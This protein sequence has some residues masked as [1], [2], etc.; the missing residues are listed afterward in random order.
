MKNIFFIGLSIIGCLQET[1]VF[2]DD[3]REEK[4]ISLPDLNKR[5]LHKKSV[6]R[7]GSYSSQS[8]VKD[9]PCA[10]PSSVVKAHRSKFRRRVLFFKDFCIAVGASAFLVNLLIPE[11]ALKKIIGKKIAPLVGYLSTA[12]VL[13]IGL[14]Y[15]LAHLLKIFSDKKT[16]QKNFLKK[17]K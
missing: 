12:G 5:A 4:N 7:E 11:K 17:K 15:S 13:L 6:N 3:I 2:S 16:S 14:D 10:L 1:L 9:D 8:G